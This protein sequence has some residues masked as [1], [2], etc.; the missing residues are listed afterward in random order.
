MAI[1]RLERTARPVIPP[2]SR[3]RPLPAAFSQ[4]WA[5]IIQGG[6]ISSKLNMP[7][8]VRLRGRLEVKVINRALTE[9][10]SRHEV[11]RTYFH[12]E[13]EELQV[14]IE[15]VPAKFPMPMVDLSRLPAAEREELAASMANRHANMAFDL[16]QPPLF[17]AAMLRLAGPKQ[18]QLDHM[19]LINMHHI[20]GDGWSLNIL[21][22]EFMILFQA[23]SQGRPSPLGKLPFQFTDFAY[24]QRQ[25][26]A[27]GALDNHMSYWREQLS[28]DRERNS[29]ANNCPYPS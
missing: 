21:T 15:P 14:R 9:I 18:E 5:W 11:L 13:G 20:L 12:P 7:Q 26:L 23:F 3:D 24:W 1:R 17:V 29:S 2:V 22:Q 4:E 19:L 6:P 28:G 27:T 10:V 25:A 8:A 16:R